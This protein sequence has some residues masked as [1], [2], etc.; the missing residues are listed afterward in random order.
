MTIYH[1]NDMDAQMRGLCDAVR[2]E[3]AAALATRGR[4]V[5]AVPGGRTPAPFFE[6][7]AGCGDLD[8]H[9]IVVLLTDERCVADDSPR[10]NGRLLRASLLQSH[11]AVAQYLPI[12]DHSC[13]DSRGGLTESVMESVAGVLPLDVCIVGMG[14]DAHTAS[15]FADSPELGKALAQDAPPLV[16]V[17]APSMGEDRVTLSA[18][19]LQSAAS[20]HILMSGADKYTALQAAML[21]GEVSDAPIRA[22]LH[23]HKRWD[24]YFNDE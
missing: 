5:L 17:S 19:A 4:A 13:G 10:S 6:M 21:A 22:I 12:Y 15:L 20:V 9:N 18:G 8:W 11:A 3:L 2:G 23:G 1:F 16:R 14:A 24:V 7:L